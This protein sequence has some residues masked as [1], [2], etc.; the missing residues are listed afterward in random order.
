MACVPGNHAAENSDRCSLCPAGYRCSDPAVP[1]VKCGVGTY[2][3][4]GAD[5]CERCLPGFLCPE[6]SENWAIVE[7]PRGAWC[8]GTPLVR[9]CPKGT[10]GNRTGARTVD[11]ACARCEP[12]YF[13]PRAGTT[14][15]TREP[16]PLGHYCVRRRGLNQATAR[17]ELNFGSTPRR[18]RLRLPSAVP[19]G[20]P[21]RACRR[22]EF[23]RL[24]GVSGRHLLPGWRER[25]LGASLWSG[26]LLSTKPR[27]TQR[28]VSS[29]W[30]R[31]ESSV[32]PLD[33]VSR[34]S[35]GDLAVRHVS[36]SRGHLLC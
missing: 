27:G 17:T 31:R 4:G 15:A 26:T 1:P 6:A 12:G 28:V 23:R 24:R 29:P 22:G 10:Y 18:P 7:C 32:G 14:A 9:R 3:G 30:L 20:N 34:R 16:C 25:R 33:Y 5:S 8:D 19:R 35:R 36:V 2:S 13:C 21:Q 11:E